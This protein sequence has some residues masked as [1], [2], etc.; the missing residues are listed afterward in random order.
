MQKI[1]LQQGGCEEVVRQ[2]TRWAYSQ[3]SNRHRV[4]DPA[5]MHVRLRLLLTEDFGLSSSLLILI[6]MNYQ[7]RIR[8]I[9]ITLTRHID[10]RLA[11]AL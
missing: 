1:L 8:S 6:H 4:T 3:L 9:T 7:V 2:K 11:E 10:Q 5:E